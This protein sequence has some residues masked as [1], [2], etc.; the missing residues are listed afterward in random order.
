VDRL[1]RLWE[2]FGAV[3]ELQIDDEFR[4]HMRERG[5]YREHR[6][7][8]AEIFESLEGAPAFFENGGA[9]R[10][11]IIMVGPTMHGRLLCVPLEPAG[12][13]GVWRVVTAFEANAGH[14]QRYQEAMQ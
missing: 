4:S 1:I 8:V 13:F 5:V 10:A 14:R 3:E 9:H 2:H 6:V 12:V 11:P 7:S